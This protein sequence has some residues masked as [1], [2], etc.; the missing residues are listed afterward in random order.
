M[1][2]KPDESTLIAYLYG[3]LNEKETK[4]LESYFQQHPEELAKLRGLD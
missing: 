4:K 3:E 2:Y 1:N